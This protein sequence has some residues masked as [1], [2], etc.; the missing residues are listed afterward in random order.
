MKHIVHQRVTTP[1]QQNWVAKLLAYDFD[2]EYKTGASNRVADALSRRDG[3]YELSALSIPV[4]LDWEALESAVTADNNLKKIVEQLRHDPTSVSL[5]SLVNN[6]LFYRNRIVI[7]ANSSWIPTLLEEFHSTPIGGHSGAYRTYRRLASSIYWKGMMKHVQKFVADCLVCQKNK[8]DMLTPAGLLQ[9][10]PIPSIVWQDIAMDFI[11]GLPW[12]HGVDCIWVI[13]DRLSKYAHF[14][15]LRHPFTAKSLADKFVKEVVRLHGVPESIISDRDPIF[16]SNFWSEFFRLMG[17]RLRLSSAY[18]PQTDG[19]TE[20]LNRCLEQYLRCFT[21][22]QPKQWGQ[23]LHWAEYSYNTSFQ[24]AAGLTPFESLYGRSPPTLRQFLPGEFRV[25]AVAEEHQDRDE[26]LRQLHYNLRKAQTQMQ[27]Q[28]NRKRRDIEF[29]EGDLV[30]LKLRPHRQ[31]SVQKRLNPK[32]APRFF[33]P[34]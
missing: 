22:E 30:L 34:F 20:V 2:V 5:Y 13:I 19:Q 31:V 3:D 24:S 1:S 33:G 8:Y 14:I 10:L 16:L 11:T 21:S 29:S 9:P 15:G 32:L 6:R 28:A 12:S 4:W 26:L 17:T 23:F 25:P 27:S 7:P 18:H